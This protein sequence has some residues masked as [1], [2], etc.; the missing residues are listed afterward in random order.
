MYGAHNPRI[1]ARHAGAALLV[2]LGAGPATRHRQPCGQHQP[3][4]HRGSGLSTSRSGQCTDFGLAEP[5]DVRR[6]AVAG[7]VS[8]N[9]RSAVDT[10]Y[11]RNYAPGLDVGTGYTGSDCR[12]HAGTTSASSRAATLRAVNFVALDERPGARSVLHRR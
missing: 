10:A 5:P 11:Q 4:R 1:G 6:A 7:S 8:V 3:S 12:C 2:T 9:S